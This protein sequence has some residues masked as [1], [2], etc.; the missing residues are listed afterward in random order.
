M[1]WKKVKSQDETYMQR[2]IRE[3]AV[4]QLLIETQTANIVSER[5]GEDYL[6]TTPDSSVHIPI[7][8]IHIATPAP[9][10]KIQLEK[11]RRASLKRTNMWRKLQD[12]ITYILLLI[13]ALQIPSNHFKEIQSTKQALGLYG[14]G[15]SNISNMFKQVKL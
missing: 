1:L 8:D 14:K 3:Q 11:S 9:P 15:K 5:T 13:L 10:N 6:D 4:K 7:E 12:L 2:T